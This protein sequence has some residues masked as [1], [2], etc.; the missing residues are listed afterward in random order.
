L[1]L[2]LLAPEIAIAV[3]AISVILLDL[4]IQR[5]GWLTLLSLAGIICAVILAMPLLEQSQQT[6]WNGLLAIDG[7]A[8]FFKIFFL[9]LVF[10]I[11]SAS[12][13]YVSRLNRFHGEFHALILLS[14][15]GMMLMASATDLISLFLSLELTAISFYALTG[16]L[17]NKQSTEAALKYVLLG[18][19]NSAMLL[20]GLALIFGFSGQTQLAAIAHSI[21][22]LPASELMAN[23]G[24]LLGL[25]L[26][27]AGFSFKTAAVPFHMW[28]PDVYEGAPTPVTLYLST[29]S[30]LAGFAVLLRV[31]L[32]SFSQPISLSQDWGIII[33][34]VS[35]LGMTLGNL[36][37]I[38]QSNIK[39]MLAYSSIAQTGYMLVALASMGFAA[40]IDSTTQASL[41]FYML[42]FALAE[43]AVFTAVI[44]AS[45]TFKSDNIA[46]YAGL[47][48]RSPVL[49]IAL[50][51]ALLSLMGLP[52]TA[53]FIAKFYVFSQA[54]ASGLLWLV[55]IAVINSVISA[56]YYLK[57]IKVMWMD[58]PAQTE[59]IKASPGPWIV[60]A[61][62]ALGIIMA[63][64]LPIW[65]MKLAELGARLILP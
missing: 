6:I 42:A 41:L 52:P 9:G 37:A 33:A 62:S 11:I 8:I 19:V 12:T 64:I 44:I 43:V 46:D 18:G 48:Q 7:T 65:G 35:G 34:L 30:K 49:A 14:G 56:F 39:R 32:T 10:L 15:L 5:K 16:F 20:Y 36:L 45:Q 40:I 63:G 24:L 3:T 2:A 55:I 47:K 26:I 13:D 57:V 28:A 17:K 1:N 51:I 29:A 61:I 31:L 25:M 53:G 38:P 4:F 58:Q 23:P 59:P 22:N 60:L 21:Q 27:L 50:T 54:V